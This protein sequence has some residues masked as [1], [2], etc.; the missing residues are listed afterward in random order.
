MAALL[1][2]E[3]TGFR[4]AFQCTRV[5]L[6]V[7]GLFLLIWSAATIAAELDKGTLRIPLLRVPR[8]A[9]PLGKATFLALLSGALSV[10]VLLLSLLLG[11]LTYGLSPVEVGAITLQ[12]RGALLAAGFAATALTLLPMFALL[13]LGVCVSCLTRSAQG[14]V[15]LTLVAALVLWGAS[16]VPGIGE[17][18]FPATLNW[19]FDVALSKA[20]GL[21]TLAFVDRVSSH[22]AVNVLWIVLLL[23]LGTARFRRRDLPT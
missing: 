5:L 2:A 9:V 13:A 12:T 21:K 17:F 18:V 23:G 14:A 7:L 3:G 16:L 6:R 8:S 22:C 11:A 10:A 15:T 19:P 1:G 4:L 20:E